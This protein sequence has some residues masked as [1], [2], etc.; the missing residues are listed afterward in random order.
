MISRISLSKK[1]LIYVS[2]RQT[3]KSSYRINRLFSKY[4]IPGIL[5]FSAV[6]VLCIFSEKK[7]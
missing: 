7:I 6:N 5:Q 2:K 1:H 4:N 3:S